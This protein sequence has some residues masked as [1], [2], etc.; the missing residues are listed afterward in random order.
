MSL[1]Y[2]THKKTE[3]REMK[4]YYQLSAEETMREVNGSTEPLTDE[5]VRQNQEKYGRNELVEGKK[6][7]TLQIFLEQYKDFLVIILIIAAVV[8]GFLG[9][10]EAAV[11]ILIVITMNAILGT[12]QTIK[13][14]Q[15]LESL[16]KLSGPEA[17]VLRG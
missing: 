3:V 12:V 4:N 8:S 15:S 10:I 1:F 17:K 5:Q 2:C 13:A 6:K 14:E 9:D 7:T 16:K 11:V